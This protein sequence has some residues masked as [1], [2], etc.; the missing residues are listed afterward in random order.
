MALQMRSPHIGYNRLVL[1]WRWDFGFFA[2]FR[3]LGWSGTHERRGVF[4]GE[5]TDFLLFP[6]RLEAGSPD[7][8]C[9]A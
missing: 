1:A 2:G 5:A 4:G 8:D 7:E 9:E 6:A 3:F